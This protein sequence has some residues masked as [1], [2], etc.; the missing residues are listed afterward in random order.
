MEYRKKKKAKKA[1]EQLSPMAVSPVR[2][3]AEAL[4]GISRRVGALFG[5][6]SE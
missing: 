1:S 6:N 2:Q 3:A 4:A 5:G